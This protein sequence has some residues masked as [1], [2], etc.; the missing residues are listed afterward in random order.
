MDINTK[1]NYCVYCHYFPNGKVYVGITSKEPEK[2]WLKDG[3]GYRQQKVVY[4]AIKK[5]GWN[6]I[7]HEVIARNVSYESAKNIEIDL[8]ELYNST[9][10]K[11]GYNISPGGDLISEESRKKI[12]KSC[13]G[14]HVSEESRK[15]MS[16]NRKGKK[17]SEEHR[18]KIGEAHRGMKMSDEFRKKMS[19]I[20]KNRHH[21]TIN[22]P[23]NIAILQY[24]LIDGAFLGR[25]RSINEA[26]RQ[27]GASKSH[28]SECAKEKRRQEMNCIWIYEN[29]ATEEYIQHRLESARFHSLYK[30]VIISRHYNYQCPVYCQTMTE[31][32]QI[33][34]CSARDLTRIIDARSS[35]NGYYIKKID[36]QEYLDIISK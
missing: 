6:N 33:I 29:M 14:R 23:R 12:S 18:R 9:D 8:I 28:I 36:V 25:Y 2:R 10:R 20:A 15:K 19:E 21:D 13:T 31:A 26:S 30:P 7:I 17:K 16:E 34:G 22:D 1:N 35:F 4:S 3:Y 11:H 32:A 24:R 5:Y 27:T